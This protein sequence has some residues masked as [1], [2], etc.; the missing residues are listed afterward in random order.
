METAV[1]VSLA[2]QY[3]TNCLLL[4]GCSPGESGL[5]TAYSV[6]IIHQYGTAKQKTIL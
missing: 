6:F 4:N 2:L 5:T 3:L 1:G